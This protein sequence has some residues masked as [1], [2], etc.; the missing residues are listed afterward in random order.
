MS[1]L[2]VAF[3]QRVSRRAETGCS[4]SARS[5]KGRRTKDRP[6]TALSATCASSMATALRYLCWYDSTSQHGNLSQALTL[7]HLAAGIAVAMNCDCKFQYCDCKFGPC[8]KSQARLVSCLK[9]S[10]RNHVRI[11]NGSKASQCYA[12]S[13]G[14]NLI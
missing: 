7:L 6:D 10:G 12:F 5:K 1:T 8:T 13:A 2:L 11:C 14:P 3:R 4:C 9:V